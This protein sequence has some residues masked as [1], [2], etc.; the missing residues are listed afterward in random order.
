M[1]GDEFAILLEH[2]SDTT[3]IAARI[4]EGFTQP[5]FVNGHDVP[6]GIS[7]GIAELTAAQHQS[8]PRPSSTAP[9]AP[10]IKPNAPEEASPSPGP[11]LHVQS[12]H[13]PSAPDRF[14]RR[15]ALTVTGGGTACQTAGGGHE[16]NATGYPDDGVDVVHLG[17]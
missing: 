17:T 4:P 5:A 11:K 1:G 10:G 13:V 14:T 8:P 6:L 16:V 3:I 12:R 9:T 2:D 15:L 7:I